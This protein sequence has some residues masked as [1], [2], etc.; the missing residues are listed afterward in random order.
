MCAL[1]NMHCAPPLRGAPLK[2]KGGTVKKIFPALRAG[3]VP[4]TFK[5]VPGPLVGIPSKITS[6]QGTCF[7]PELT[8]KFLEMFGCSPIWSTPLHSDGNLLVERL[9]QTLKKT[10]AHV[11]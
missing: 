11:C 7:T 2:S 1:P 4:P 8:R 5:F 10:L 3:L 9:N 6:D